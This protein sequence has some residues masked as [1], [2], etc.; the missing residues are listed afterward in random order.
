M[1]RGTAIESTLQMHHM[2]LWAGSE[3]VLLVAYKS[4][5]TGSALKLVTR[6]Y[7]LFFSGINQTVLCQK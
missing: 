6:I 5:S 4:G 7:S 2:R 1:G 3:Q